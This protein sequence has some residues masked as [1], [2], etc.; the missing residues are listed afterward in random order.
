MSNCCNESEELLM[1]KACES[2]ESYCST[3]Q[4]EM[5]DSQS[6]CNEKNKL[7]CISDTDENLP[8]FKSNEGSHT[9]ISDDL[10]ALKRTSDKNEDIL[11][12]LK[13]VKFHKNKVSLYGIYSTKPILVKL[14]DFLSKFCLI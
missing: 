12:K 5:A 1:I 3:S 13:L 14:F 4:V 9:S 2:V 8:G 6:H 10:S 7:A 11:R